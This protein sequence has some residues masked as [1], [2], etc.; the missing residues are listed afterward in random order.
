V[1]HHPWKGEASALAVPAAS[2]ETLVRAGAV[3]ALV[4]ATAALAGAA[5]DLRDGSTTRE[6]ALR[7]VLGAAAKTGVATGLGA[8]VARSLRGGPLLSATAM[9][10]T[11]AAALY[12]MDGASQSTPTPAPTTRRKTP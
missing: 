7:S 5:R 12:A 3:G 8:F 2:P 10:V 9:V 4:G 6:A 11:G 1:T